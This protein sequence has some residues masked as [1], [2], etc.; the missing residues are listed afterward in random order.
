MTLLLLYLH[1]GVKVGVV[2]GVEGGVVAGVGPPVE[3]GVDGEVV[4]VGVVGANSHH[5]QEED[6]DTRHAEYRWVEGWAS[7]WR[8]CPRRT[9]CHG[10]LSGNISLCRIIGSHCTGGSIERKSSFQAFL[11]KK[12]IACM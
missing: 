10:D 4:V 1:S 9:D 6:G 7:V 2:G 12:I 3:P 5:Q 11:Q 8:N